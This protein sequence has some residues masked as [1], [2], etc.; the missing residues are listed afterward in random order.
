VK[1]TLL[2]ITT[3]WLVAFI[4][5]AEETHSGSGNQGTSLGKIVWV[6]P[7][8]DVETIKKA[9]ALVEESG[10]E[11]VVEIAD[12]P[13]MKP[14]AVDILLSNRAL[15]VVWHGQSGVLNLLFSNDNETDLVSAKSGSPDEEALFL[16][17]LLVARSDSEQ[18]S[19][20]DLLLT[21]PDEQI[22][23]TL[24]PKPSPSLHLDKTP[25]LPFSRSEWRFGVG[26]NL[27]LHMDAVTW[28]QNAVELMLPV[29]QFHKEAIARLI[30]T[31]GLPVIIGEKGKEWLE[32]ETIEI[33]L[34][35][36]LIP[37][38]FKKTIAEIGIGTGLIKSSAT[39]FLSSGHSREMTKISGQVRLWFALLLHTSR[40]LNVRFYTDISVVLNAPS[41]SINDVG[42]FG[43][44]PLQWGSG[45]D[46]EVGVLNNYKN[47]VNFLN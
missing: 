5:K 33:F 17:E 32:I 18:N 31:L 9:M 13:P 39:A 22:E 15:A 47:E 3:L 7:A 30:I 12:S 23:V 24:K 11:I 8:S 28:V 4:A 36:G 41:F 46:I 19:V 1:K 45:L 29:W 21:V 43:A 35:A 44:F 26:Y 10:F 16:R 40:W 25:S 2:I 37:L 38:R 34:G 20:S 14:E 42:N 6:A 27:R